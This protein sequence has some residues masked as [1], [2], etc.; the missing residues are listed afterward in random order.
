MSTNIFIVPASLALL[1]N[2]VLHTPSF[3]LQVKALNNISQDKS[4]RNG[5]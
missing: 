3:I 1:E 4:Y 2:F 5:A